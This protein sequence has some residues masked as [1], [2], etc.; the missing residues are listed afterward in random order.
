MTRRWSSTSRLPLADLTANAD[1]VLNRDWI[2][3][4]IPHQ[5]SM[6]LL[7]R[8]D[9]WDANRVECVATSHRDPA[10]PLRAHGRLG[11]AA[12]IEYAAQA[13]A[14]HGAL[15]DGVHAGAASARPGML[16]SARGVTVAVERLDDIADDLTVIAT[17]QAADDRAIAY[18]FE[19]RAG[20]RI[21]L[22]GRAT[23]MLGSA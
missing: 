2:A 11:A 4:R 6:C 7:D 16:A 22:A 5:G 17:R 18:A 1:H 12:G 20:G 14:V 10:N 23:V 19:V 8:V 21:L 13:M 15:C 3:A 9:S